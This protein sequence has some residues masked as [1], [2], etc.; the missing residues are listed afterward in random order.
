VDV[1]VTGATGFVGRHVV[2]RLL[3]E[4]F[5]VRALSRGAGAA[6]MPPGVEPVPGDVT[7][8][9]SLRHALEGVGGVVHLVAIIVERGDRTFS[10]V[11]H[12]GTENLV[13]AMRQ[14]GVST[15]VHQSA[16]GV[17][18]GLERFPYLHS[19]W[20][21]EETVRAG[22]LAYTILRP[23]VIHGRGA[24]FFR[25]IVWNLRWLPVFPLPAGGRTRFQ[26]VHIDDVATAII[27]SLRSPRRDT[28]DVAGP[29]ILT[30]EQIAG[31]V[32]TAM[33]K[34][35]PF[36]RI[37]LWA[38]RP[39]A[40]TQRLRRNP[41]VTSGQ[42]DMVVLDNTTGLDATVKAFGFEPKRMADTDLR[43]LSEL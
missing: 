21:G 42:L 12:L 9:A 27:A 28:F 38:A 30:F 2:P 7:E 11:N 1:L 18:P 15:L 4:G 25:P 29:E 23:G 6:R 34:P 5:G 19:K 17:G 39:F 20:L 13:A 22:G 41:L 16:L 14:A 3:G 40:W 10:G 32:M 26:P 33:G 43:W 37:P 36:M 8:P 31:V 24:G 35:R